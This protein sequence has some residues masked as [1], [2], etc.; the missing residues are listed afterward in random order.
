MKKGTLSSSVLALAVVVGLIAATS[1][2][3]GQSVLI[4]INQ[5][6]LNDVTF[7]TTGLAA[8]ANTNVAENAGVDLIGYFSSSLTSVRTGVAGTL[9]PAGAG[10]TAYNEWIADNYQN[11]FN[12][13]DLNLFSSSRIPVQDFTT[14]SAAFT[15]TVGLNL[16]SYLAELP[17]TGTEGP[18]YAGYSRQP[19]TLIG[20]WE[21]VPEPSSLEQLALGGIILSG[22]IAWRARRGAIRR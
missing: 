11:G 22:L 21:V 7:T 10:T 15:G 12:D 16:S 4:D 2:V 20:Y 5:Y 17:A 18:I 19:G 8:F 9:T 14:S 1:P 13:V 6:N 3:V